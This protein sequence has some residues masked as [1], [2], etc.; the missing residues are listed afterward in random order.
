VPQESPFDF[1]VSRANILE[2]LGEKYKPTKRLHD[3]LVYYWLHF[4]DIR[5]NV[6]R[7]LE[8]GIQTDRS[9]RMWE[10]FFPNAMIFG[11]DI[12]PQCKQFE[13]SRRRVFIGDQSDE[14]LLRSVV[15]EAG[16]SLDII[17]D[18]GSHHVEH[19]LKTFNVLFPVFRR[20]VFM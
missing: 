16:G 12:D 2:E 5:L 8:I 9:M 1:A 4:R 15:D 6:R 13:G 20:T 17:I 19:Q 14:T 3:Y 7:V 18:D 11:L 10:E